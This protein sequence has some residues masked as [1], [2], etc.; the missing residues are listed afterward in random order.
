MAHEEFIR[1]LYRC[2]LQREADP[3]GLAFHMDFI[4]TFPGSYTTLIGHFIESPEYLQR[5]Q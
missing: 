5:F 3:G 2:A 1:Q 4:T